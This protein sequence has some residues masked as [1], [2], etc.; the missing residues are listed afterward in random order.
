MEQA[1]ASLIG[2]H[3]A[4]VVVEALLTIQL[5]SA[6]QAGAYFDSAAEL[7]EF[8]KLLTP[9]QESSLWAYCSSTSENSA[10]A[11]ARLQYPAPAMT[12]Q[13]IQ[14][15]TTLK[16]Q[17][18]GF[19]LVHDAVPIAPPRKRICRHTAGTAMQPAD[20]L[21]NLLRQLLASG[22]IETIIECDCR[23][24]SRKSIYLLWY[25]T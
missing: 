5:S 10:I 3:A 23:I 15:R 2:V 8:C 20:K 21:W 22:N 7:H 11:A 1:F 19:A 17:N 18:S 9:Q 25:S 4:K 13:Q 6:K 14:V 12:Q 24:L 16:T